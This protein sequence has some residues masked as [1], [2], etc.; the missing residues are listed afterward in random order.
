MICDRRVSASLKGKVYKTVVVTEERVGLGGAARQRGSGRGCSSV[1]VSRGEETP[2]LP[3]AGEQPH[4][5]PIVTTPLEP[6]KEGGEDP[7]DV[8]SLPLLRLV[9][10]V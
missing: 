9:I 1:P 6:T 7:A 5:R 10:H 3:C 8:G 2:C 4:V